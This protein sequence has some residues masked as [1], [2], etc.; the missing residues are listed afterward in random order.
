MR[1]ISLLCSLMLLVACSSHSTS[2]A[3]VSNSGT[4]EKTE[5][6]YSQNLP[7][8]DSTVVNNSKPVADSVPEKAYSRQ[9]VLEEEVIADARNAGAAANPRNADA[10]KAPVQREPTLPLEKTFTLQLAAVREMQQAL[11]YAKRYEI[12]PEQ[13]GVAKIL[14]KG[15]L[16]YVLAYGV[17]TSREAA[18]LAKA[19]L[20]AQGIPEPWVRTLATLEELSKEATANG[21]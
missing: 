6:K 16:W 8:I 17:F 4:P 21:Y 11:D 5:S 3:K 9:F 7:S 18:D 2:D 14:S 10:F 19:D 12:D 1:V 20:Q 13:A 15:Q